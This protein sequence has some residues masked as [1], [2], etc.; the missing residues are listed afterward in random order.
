[1]AIS[2]TCGVTNT[3]YFVFFNLI[4]FHFLNTLQIHYKDNPKSR[5]QLIWLI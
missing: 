4:P 2:E 5:K 3:F 1:M